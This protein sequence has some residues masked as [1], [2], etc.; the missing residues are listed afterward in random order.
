MDVIIT[1]LAKETNE[2]FVK[3]MRVLQ[4]ENTMKCNMKYTSLSIACPNKCYVY[5]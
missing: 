2:N 4:G 5:F 1:W 3:L